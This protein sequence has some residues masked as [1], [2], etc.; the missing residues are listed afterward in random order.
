MQKDYFES[1]CREI[2]AD[3]QSIRFAGIAN[4]LGSLIATQYRQGLIPL[5]T[6]E[7]TSQYSYKQFFVL[8][9]VKTLNQR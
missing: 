5:M 4:H 2:L 6:K 3:D 7:E 8:L 1:L 9:Y